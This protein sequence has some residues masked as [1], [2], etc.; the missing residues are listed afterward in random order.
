MLF[1]RYSVKGL[2][3]PMALMALAD[4]D[5]YPGSLCR[6][7]IRDPEPMCTTAAIVAEHA[8]GRLH[9]TRGPACMNWPVTYTLHADDHPSGTEDNVQS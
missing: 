1:C 6:H 2:V 4:H 7:R 9:V 3:V 5:N 8:T